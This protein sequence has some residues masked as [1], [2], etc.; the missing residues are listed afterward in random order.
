MKGILLFFGLM[1]TVAPSVAMAAGACIGKVG[2]VYMESNATLHFD[3]RP[4]PHW[5]CNAVHGV[6]RQFIAAQDSNKKEQYA[7][8]LTAH[9]SNA[10]V[11][12]WYDWNGSDGRNRCYA[13]N[14]AL[15]R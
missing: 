8:L 1:L 9:A 10:T 11:S 12:V 5:G 6:R 7:A 4:T 14:T 15:V 3:I 13:Y 2:V